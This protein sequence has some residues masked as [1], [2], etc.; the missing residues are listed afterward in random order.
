MNKNKITKILLWL[1]IAAVIIT[2][3]SESSPLYKLNPWSDAN[4]YLTI[5]RDLL[6]GGK[7]YTDLFDHKGPILYFIYTI[8]SCISST[9][10]F[11]V[12]LLEIICMYFFLY[13]SEKILSLFTTKRHIVAISAL[14]IITV[15]S[16]AF[17]YGGGSVEELF[18][19]IFQITNYICLN[20]IIKN[21]SFSSKECIYIGLFAGLSLLTKFT[22]SGYFLG[23]AICLIIYQFN[24]D[25]SKL[26]T[27]I[28]YTFISFILVLCVSSLYFV[29]NHNVN[30]F[31]DT[32]FKFNLFSYKS[33]NS[34]PVR[35]FAMCKAVLFYIKNNI[36]LVSLSLLSILYSII[37]FKKSYITLYIVSTFISWYFISFIGSK[38]IAYYI[39]PI[40]IY[41]VFGILLLDDSKYKNAICIVI[42]ICCIFM[43]N[44]IKDL[45]R[46]DYV[47]YEFAN[48]IGDSSFLVYK[49]YDQ[50]FYMVANE[51]P[52][53]RYFTTTN[54]WLPNYEEDTLSCINEKQIEYLISIDNELDLPNYE[55][56]ICKTQ[57]YDMKNKIYRLYKLSN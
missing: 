24:K 34:L 11:G 17:S 42:S 25:R 57:K 12:Y 16:K 32:Y 49:G 36:L 30:D 8:A 37:H 46:K 54:G 5:G 31:I 28:T 53:C 6:N 9:S 40:C 4:I 43:S 44:N 20:R 19:P 2:I 13:Y 39:L 10:F 29:I 15:T 52:G 47:Q 21:E 7:L 1:A 35:L 14:G 18:L 23:V 56:V 55:L 26:L 48:I 45:N 51:N 50:G 27:C 41:I 3:F 33:P 38:F 22:L